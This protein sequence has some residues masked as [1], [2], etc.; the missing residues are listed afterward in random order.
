M[1]LH[2]LVKTL[3]QGR[4]IEHSPQT[5]RSRNVIERTVRLELLKKPEALLGKGEREISIARERMQGRNSKAVL[6]LILH[7]NALSQTGHAGR[8]EECTQG[9]FHLERLSHARD[10]PGRQQ[11]VPS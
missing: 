8:F 1:A 7:N 9:H 5:Q 10:Q 3:R 2:N 6:S 4:H 11:R